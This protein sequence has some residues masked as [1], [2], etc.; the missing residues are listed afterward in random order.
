MT[1]AGSEDITGLLTAWSEGNKEAL[2]RLI[3]AVYPE[4]RR[5]AR[6][7]NLTCRYEAD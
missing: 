3:P 2:S 1:L 4:L 6:L 5:I 7:E